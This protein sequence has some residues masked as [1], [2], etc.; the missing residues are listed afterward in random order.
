MKIILG[1]RDLYDNAN[2]IFAIWQLRMH[3]AALKTFESLVLTFSYTMA[4]I[5]TTWCNIRGGDPKITGI[6]M[7]RAN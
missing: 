4:T 5:C 7:W 2:V 6:Y 3:L 1:E